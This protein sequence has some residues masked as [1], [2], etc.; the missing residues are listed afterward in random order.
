MFPTHV[1]MNGIRSSLSGFTSNVPH[2]RGYERAELPDGFHQSHVP[3]TRGY[4]RMGQT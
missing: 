4:E 3:H 2:T 1:G